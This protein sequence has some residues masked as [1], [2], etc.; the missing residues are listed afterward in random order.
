MARPR[1]RAAGSSTC[2][3][4]IAVHRGKTGALIQASCV[5]GGAGRR[6]RRPGGATPCGASAQDIGL[7]FQVADDVLD[8][9]G[10][11]DAAGQDRRARTPRWPSPPTS[12]LLGVEGARAEAAAGSPTPRSST[13]DAAGV[14]SAALGRARALYCDSSATDSWTASHDT[15]RHRINGPG[16][17]QAPPARPAPAAGRR[18]SA[19][20]SSTAARV[21]GGHIGASLGVVE[22]AIALLYEFDS[23]TDKIVWD[24]GHQ[25]Y[26]W[27]LLT[28]RN[29]GFPTLRQTGGISGFLKR[30]E[31]EHDQFGAGHAGTAMSAAL[32]MATARDLTGE[33]LQGR[34]RRGRRRADLRPLLRGDEQRRPLRP[35]HHPDRQRQRDVASRPTSAPSARRSAAS[36]PTRAPT[37][38]ASRSSS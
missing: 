25:A 33:R 8:A 6:E 21:T 32:G 16:R 3:E 29:D 38:C 27:K 30:S 28:G 7:A 9:T 19:T 15:A 2:A 14:P 36:S 23:P 20:G 37:G 1:G 34:G 4:L 35:R 5:L 31:S 10:T 12:Q 13:S 17:S 18:R 11:S 24:V 26:A 22:L